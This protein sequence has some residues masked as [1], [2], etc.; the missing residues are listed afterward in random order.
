LVDLALK[1][2]AAAVKLVDLYTRKLAIAIANEQQT[3]A[4]NLYIMA[5]RSVAA[6]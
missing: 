5:T 6:S 2:R 1:G 4:P 3:I